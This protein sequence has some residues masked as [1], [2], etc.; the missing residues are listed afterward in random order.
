M[1]S[2][3]I[4]SI[5]NRSI[6]IH[7]IAGV[8]AVFNLCSWYYLPAYGESPYLT[9]GIKAYM[10]GDYNKAAGLLG[11]AESAEFSNPIMHYYLA[12]TLAHLKE[13]ESAIREYRI[14]YA[15]DPDGDVGR[16]CHLALS[17]YGADLFGE[18][19][20]KH[21]KGSVTA[22]GKITFSSDPVIQQAVVAMH[23]Q[24]DQLMSAY[25][26]P[27]VS[28]GRNSYLRSYV[29]Q[30][31]LYEDNARSTSAAIESA[32]NLEN[33]LNNKSAHNKV[34]LDPAGTNLYIRKYNYLDTNNQSRAP[35]TTVRGKIV[36]KSSASGP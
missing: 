1:K 19:R 5:K 25:H 13:H 34:Q 35:I 28:Y 36:N 16:Q 4:F 10:A 21:G 2:M 7:L 9:K 31:Q 27:P 32:N 14:A 33:L 20:S 24:V 29:R 22:S 15:L 26:S 6:N 8:I 30:R 11:A 3:S 18:K 12:N 23:R 17:V